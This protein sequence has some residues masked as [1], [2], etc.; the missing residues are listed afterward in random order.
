[1]KFGR[2]DP[3]N[4]MS[5]KRLPCL[6]VCVILARSLRN[7]SCWMAQCALGTR[8]LIVRGVVCGAG[9]QTPHGIAEEGCAAV[10]P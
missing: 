8:V 9:V 5:I 3:A 10:H 4:S 7:M 1:M 6:I 2:R